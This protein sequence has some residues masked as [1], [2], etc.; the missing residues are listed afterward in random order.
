M[1]DASEL[2]VDLRCHGIRVDLDGDEIRLRAPRGILTTEMVRAVRAIR[3]QVQALLVAEEAEIAWRVAA[4]T[5]RIGDGPLPV[6]LVVDD[7][8]EEPGTCRS[9]G[10][11]TPY[12]QT[13]KC[14]LCCLASSRLVAASLSA[15]GA[16]KELP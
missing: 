16:R 1:T 13:G 6:E 4:M 7:R 15:D 11:P 14:T 5:D 12:G 9:C 10:D 3:P 2:L 8:P